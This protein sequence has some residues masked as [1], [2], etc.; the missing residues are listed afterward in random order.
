[1]K[2][3]VT[4][5]EILLRLLADD[6]QTLTQA[7]KFDIIFGGGEANVA[8]SLAQFGYESYFVTKLVDNE[9][10]DSAINFL[11]ERGVKT[12]YIARG[13]DRMG[14]YYSEKGSSQR[15]FFVVYDRKNSSI[16][17][18][19]PG[20]FDLDEIFEG[21]S[22]FHL[23]GITPALS[24]KAR[25]LT[26]AFMVEAKK[27]GC[28]VSF[29]LNYRSTLWSLDE[30]V[31][32]FEDLLPYV[33][34]CIGVLP[35]LHDVRGP[36]TSE[37]LEKIFREVFPKYSFKLIVSTLRENI[38]ASFN[39]LSACAFDGEKFYHTDKLNLDI[40]DRVGGGDSFA[41]G[42]ICALLDGKDLDE[43]LGFGINASAIKHT[44][45][46]DCNLACR[47]EIEELQE[48][49]FLEDRRINY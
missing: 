8:I 1:M 38:S 42:L 5:G 47:K 31:A 24:P 41:A 2:K 10:G 19:E 34:I 37:G 13:G 3:I 46:G 49:G 33:D 44:I 9:I 26:K 7:D 4:M 17:G 21:A 12:D 23:S 16:C 40:I 20:D 18:A 35:E 22:L 30:A 15:P 11:R 43:A 14:L 25:E 36:L 45:D 48:R 29:D 28:L 39:R 27:R 32:C 6:R